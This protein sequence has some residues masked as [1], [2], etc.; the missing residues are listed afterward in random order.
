MPEY[1]ISLGH[2]ITPT[3][4]LVPQPQTIGMPPTRRT[5]ALSGL[6]TDELP[7]VPFFWSFLTMPQYT[8][9]LTQCGLLTATTALVSVYVQ[10]QNY[11]W[12]TRNGTIVKPEIGKDAQRENYRVRD[13]TFYVINLR[14]QS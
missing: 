3:A 10:D 12:V 5:L 6:V 9:L 13:V 7:Y 1:K 2:D 14:V 11:D 4:P 8:A